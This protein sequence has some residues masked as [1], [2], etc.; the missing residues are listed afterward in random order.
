MALTANPIFFPSE[1][2]I[3]THLQTHPYT[4]DDYAQHAQVHQAVASYFG[5]TVANTPYIGEQVLVQT[6]GHAD[7]SFQNQP[8][9][10]MDL[11]RRTTAAL[12]DCG[13]PKSR[14]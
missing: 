6:I 14:L 10:T 1:P 13:L 8:E 4:K 3:L 11:V 9:K 7:L 5:H 2:H 12:F